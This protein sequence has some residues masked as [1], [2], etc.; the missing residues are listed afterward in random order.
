MALLA[1][2]WAAKNGWTHQ[3]VII[4]HG[5]RAAAA[6]EAAHAAGMLKKAGIPVQ[7]KQLSGPFPASAIQ[8]WARGRRRQLLA[9]LARQDGAVILTGHHG[10]D[11]AETIAMR[12]AHG[13]GFAGLAGISKAGWYHG[14]LF[15]RPLLAASRAS[16]A[17][18]CR[19]AGFQ[20]IADPSN[21]D[22][23]FERVRLR[24]YLA[25]DKDR[26]GQLIR[27]GQLSA[28]LQARIDHELAEFLD[29][30]CDW[31]PPLE[32]RVDRHRFLAL[33]QLAAARFLAC[34]LPVIGGTDYPPAAASVALLLTRLAEGGGAT[35]SG[36]LLAS[37]PDQLLIMAETGRRPA[38]LE[39][40]RAGWF[41]FAGRWLVY[42]PVPVIWQ[43]L[44]KSGTLADKNKAA[45]PKMLDN[46]SAPA[47]SAFP[48]A[49]PLDDRG[50]TT[51]IYP[52][53]RPIAPGEAFWQDS[54]DHW[55]ASP[56]PRG[57]NWL[58]LF[59]PDT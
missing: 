52:D 7:V 31:R 59:A 9:G 34:L 1:A 27:L 18:Y 14:A 2:S 32:M 6:A 12:L 36:C 37:K 22:R 54:G 30:A 50:H 46:W 21:Q 55:L 43:E 10:D 48:V 17:D 3:A 25:I 53:Y 35:L 47:R 4:D 33:P 26:T 45:Y 20:P 11:Q 28:R 29:Q 51:H 57:T 58:R 5:L 39:T 23:R 8:E 24:Q 42:A 15:V 40:D 44:G 19:Q 41:V 49:L 16:L 56:L 13:S 38:R